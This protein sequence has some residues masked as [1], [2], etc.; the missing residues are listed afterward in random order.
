MAGDRSRFVCFV[1]PVACPKK[2]VLMIRQDLVDDSGEAVTGELSM[3]IL[4]C[5]SLSA[6]TY[7]NNIALFQN[8]A[9]TAVALIDGVGFGLNAGLDGF[10]KVHEIGFTEA[11]CL[12]KKLVCLVSVELLFGQ[13]ASEFKVVRYGSSCRVFSRVVNSKHKGRR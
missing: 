7:E 8:N 5:K 4:F 3:G 11:S 10:K 9:V 13:K 2:M 12:G 6:F 1:R